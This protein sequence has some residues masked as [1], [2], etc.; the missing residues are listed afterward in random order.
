MSGDLKMKILSLDLSGNKNAS[1]M[2]VPKNKENV[3]TWREKILRIRPTSPQPET[4]SDSGDVPLTPDLSSN[5]STTDSDMVTKIINRP[6]SF[7]DTK[8]VSIEVK[9][10]LEIS[11]VCEEWFATKIL[12]RWR[13]T[14]TDAIN[15][16]KDWN[17]GIRNNNN[18]YAKMY[19]WMSMTEKQ[20]QEILRLMNAPITDTYQ[21][22]L[23]LGGILE[24]LPKS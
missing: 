12:K 14:L 15:N 24:E 17:V 9:R 23:S 10:W 18:M 13:T 11:Q 6:V 20:R 21:T 5:T 3:S 2:E 19:N 4:S 1:S 7:V 8:S 16:P 22:D